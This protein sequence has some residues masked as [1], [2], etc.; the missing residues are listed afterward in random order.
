M[1]FCSSP[2]DCT[3][4]SRLG[5]DKTP[6]AAGEHDRTG[7]IAF[8]HRIDWSAR[9][10]RRPRPCNSPS[11]GRIR[12]NPSVQPPRRAC[13]RGSAAQRPERRDRSPPGELITTGSRRSPTRVEQLAQSLRCLERNRAFRRD[14]FRT[15]GIA[16]EVAASH[17]NEA[18][19][20]DHRPAA[21]FRVRPVDRRGLGFAGHGIGRL[22][23]LVCRRRY[24]PAIRGQRIGVA[25]GLPAVS[26]S[27]ESS[28]GNQLHLKH[29]FAAASCW[30]SL[31][32]RVLHRFEHA[33]VRRP[34][35]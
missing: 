14:P 1:T 16:E 17:Q 2:S 34:S 13:V 10:R 24:F 19:I 23:G 8:A 31:A 33:L 9:H 6:D 28:A 5:A 29:V 27:T 12:R 22:R 30:I 21:R 20:V 7:R 4:K 35:R 15:I 32:G 11:P 3:L 25:D 26:R 18:H